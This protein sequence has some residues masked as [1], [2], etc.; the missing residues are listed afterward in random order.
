MAFDDSN[1]NPDPDRRGSS[2]DWTAVADLNAGSS[3]DGGFVSEIMDDPGGRFGNTKLIPQ[4]LAWLEA[5]SYIDD[6]WRSVAG[7]AQSECRLTSH[8]AWKSWEN[9]FIE[10]VLTAFG[11]MTA[12]D[13][14]QHDAIKSPTYWIVTCLLMLPQITNRFRYTAIREL[15]KPEDQDIQTLAAADQAL[16]TYRFTTGQDKRTLVPGE[17][18]H[19]RALSRTYVLV[20]YSACLLSKT[21]DGI[22]TVLRMTQSTSLSGTTRFGIGL[23]G[24]LLD[25]W[26]QAQTVVRIGDRFHRADLH[27]RHGVVVPSVESQGPYIEVLAGPM[28]RLVAA[29]GPTFFGFLH[30]DAFWKLLEQIDTFL[31]RF[32]SS[33]IGTALTVLRYLITAVIGPAVFAE[34]GLSYRDFEVRNLGV[35]VE[36]N[37]AGDY[38]L[39]SA[40][41]GAPYKIKLPAG[42]VMILAA[43]GAE[44]AGAIYHIGPLA[45]PS[46]I[47]YGG[48]AALGLAGAVTM[49]PKGWHT[50]QK[51]AEVATG[52]CPNRV[53]AARYTRD[54]Y[55]AVRRHSLRAGLVAL[56]SIALQTFGSNLIEPL[57]DWM[58]GDGFIDWIEGFSNP[59]AIALQVILFVATTGIACL[60]VETALR[61]QKGPAHDEAYDAV[62][63]QKN[64]ETNQVV[65]AEYASILY[66][67]SQVRGM[68]EALGVSE[69]EGSAA[70]SAL[71]HRQR[72]GAILHDPDPDP[73]VPT[74]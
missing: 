67:S 69:R 32:V 40:V 66:P 27:K 56:F 47:E 26:V 54:T 44:V 73:D 18:C 14:M 5:R 57:L 62:S 59:L 29:I 51:I 24:G 6:E 31:S 33:E 68:R 28:S 60:G 2:A 37:L 61:T 4:C 52:D 23:V 11:W 20:R 12:G 42:L 74:A 8:R 70:Q 53:L 65:D 39:S 16:V 25:G 64:S 13:L 43:A 48:V 3:D 10:G 30:M 71:L 9:I 22:A 63:D 38:F 34:G 36:R 46:M 41:D 19:E 35:V 21:G 17:K 7:A 45:D 49:L 55:M 15:D 1:P 50:W 58:T 72:S